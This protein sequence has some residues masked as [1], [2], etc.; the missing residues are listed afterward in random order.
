MNKEFEDY[1]ASRLRRYLA[2]RQIVHLQWRDKLDSVGSVRIKPD[3][4]FGPAVGLI[5][6]VADSKYK[7]TADGFGRE[8]DYYQLLAY[9]SALNLPE[10]L[11]I[12][13]QHDGSTPPRLV[14]VRNL[15][16]GCA[17]GHSASTALPRTS[18]RNY[19]HWLTTLPTRCRIVLPL[20][21][22]K[23]V[24]SRRPDGIR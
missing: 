13:C 17:P 18:S 19:G 9:T 4:V 11:L 22:M 23:T 16:L 12:Y 5:T 21:A 2:A 7:V 14:D 20:S 15:G 8:A 1:V 10:G 6:Y 24:R 3:L